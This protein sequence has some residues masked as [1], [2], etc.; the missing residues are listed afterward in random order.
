[1]VALVDNQPRF[2]ARKS[3]SPKT[4][5]PDRQLHISGRRY[6]T[7]ELGRWINR[8]PITEEG[9]WNVYA[10]VSNSPFDLADYLG[11]VDGKWE[12]SPEQEGDATT[13]AETVTSGDYSS[14]CSPWWHI[15]FGS[16]SL[17]ITFNLTSHIVFEPQT[18]PKWSW[19]WTWLDQNAQ[20]TWNSTTDYLQRKSAARVHEKLHIKDVSAAYDKAK[21]FLETFEKKYCSYE[22]CKKAGEKAREGAF[23]II[24]VE[25]AKSQGNWH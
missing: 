16:S 14:K 20:N 18:S 9:G 4:H 11:L 21:K 24:R 2:R 10:F 25:S 8:D 23:K 3:V 6:Y 19:N 22:E 13:V 5:T 15:W 7:P 1:M 17:S 12:E